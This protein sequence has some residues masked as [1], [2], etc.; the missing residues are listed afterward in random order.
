M[1]GFS[2]LPSVIIPEAIKGLA[3]GNVR[4]YL[5]NRFNASDLQE[6]K[7]GFPCG[8]WLVC[9]IQRDKEN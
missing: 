4:Q 6:Y 9:C 8:H 7:K 2:F 1:R 5:A 3:N